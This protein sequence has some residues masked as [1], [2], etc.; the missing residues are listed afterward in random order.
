MLDSKQGMNSLTRLEKFFLT[1][2]QPHWLVVGVINMSLLV[3]ISIP[4]MICSYVSF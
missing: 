1:S 4:M 2:Y 3:A